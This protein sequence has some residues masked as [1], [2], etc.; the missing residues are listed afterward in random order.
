M[1]CEICFALFFITFA[2][3]V[4][5][6][7]ADALSQNDHQN[8]Q[9]DDNQQQMLTLE[10][11]VKDADGNPV[12]GAIVIPW[13]L[14]NS[15]GAHS[16]WHKADNDVGPQPVKTEMDGRAIVSYPKFRFPGEA[17]RV[18]EVTMSIDHP[19]HPYVNM[20]P[21]RVPRTE[22]T[23][24]RMPLGAAIE[25]AVMLDHEQVVSDSIVA[26]WTGGRTWKGDVG[27]TTTENQTYRIPPFEDGPVRFIFV[28]LDGAI[29]THFSRIEEV[30]VDVAKGPIKHEVTLESAVSFRGKLSDNVPRPVKNGRIKLS[31]IK[32]DAKPQYAM[33]WFTSTKVNEDG[34]FEVESWPKDSPVQ[35]TAF[36]DGF[37][38][39]ASEK[40]P[41]FAEERS[42]DGVLRPQV[43]MQPQNSEI[44]IEMTPLANCRIN[45]KD[46]FGNP[47]PGIVAHA[48]PMAGWWNSGNS[49]YGAVGLKAGEVLQAGKHE[50]GK[51]SPGPIGGTTNEDG[52]VE[53]GLPAITQQLWMRNDRWQM[54][55]GFDGRGMK[56][57]V[58]EAGT[59]NVDVVMHPVGLKVLGDWRDLVALTF[60]RMSDT[61]EA[62]ANEHPE[63]RETVQSLRDRFGDNENALTDPKILI[64]AYTE[65]AAACREV[66]E[67]DEAVKYDK[68]VA[69]LKKLKH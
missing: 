22:P 51:F 39:T 3:S 50:R 27:W 33:G 54:S 12:A 1:R 69:I 65:L 48:S 52:F 62:M 40:P 24:T 34:T 41:M 53:L 49:I 64:A 11:F 18:I 46:A 25:V 10:L 60:G 45:A 28:R 13:G 66:G 14:R 30:V 16:R 6:V 43:F 20:V 68:R 7:A 57:E 32:H 9:S 17:D 35:L 44:T 2:S 59:M 37:I 26:M 19:D 8:S 55:G 15:R 21:V 29:P 23:E 5:L 67:D 42:R 31:T 58:A 47:L 38:A 56:I 36:C 63:I 61:Y 4:L